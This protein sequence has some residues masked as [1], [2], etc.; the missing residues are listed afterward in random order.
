MNGTR[1]K[2]LVHIRDASVRDIELIQ[3]GFSIDN[4]GFLLNETEKSIELVTSFMYTQT[5]CRSNQFNKKINKFERATMEWEKK[6]FFPD[7]YS[8]FHGCNLTI[9]HENEKEFHVEYESEYYKFNMKL[10]QMLNFK[11]LIK[12]FETFAEALKD[13]EVDVLIDDQFFDYITINYF[14]TP[15]Y[16]IEIK[17]LIFVIP[18]GELYTPLEKMFLP[19]QPEVWI[20]IV[21]TLLIGL[22]SIQAINFCS[23]SQELRFRTKHQNTN[24]QLGSHVSHW[25]SV[26]DSWKKLRAL[27][28]H[29]GHHLVLDRQDLLKLFVQSQLFKFL[30]VDK[31][32]PAAESFAELIEKDFTFLCDDLLNA[33]FSQ[34]AQ[35]RGLSV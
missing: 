7:K 4:V 34:M 33:H 19:F 9:G 1:L 21:L 13:D 30:R 5:K 35:D 8:N 28:A 22:G 11:I 32:K 25:R 12:Q 14:I 18:P 31:R 20:A 17:E 3:D 2:H 6:T 10:G 27:S 16:P 26:Q 15:S 24:N 29:V 23:L